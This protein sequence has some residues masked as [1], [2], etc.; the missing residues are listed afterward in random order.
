M[1][2]RARGVF[3]AASVSC[4]NHN[5]MRIT[6][7]GEGHKAS[8]SGCLPLAAPI[9]LSPLL[10]LTPCGPERVWGGGGGA[11]EHGHG[12][13]SLTPEGRTRGV[14][15]AATHRS[16]QALIHER[17]VTPP[18]HPTKKCIPRGR[19]A[20][21][22]KGP[23][24][25]PRERSD[26]WLEEVAEAVGGGYCR[27]QMPLKLAPAVRE[28]VAGHRLGA[29]DG[30]GTPP[31]PSCNTSLQISAGCSARRGYQ[32]WKGDK[33]FGGARKCTRRS[34]TNLHRTQ[35]NCILHPT[36]MHGRRGSMR[37][38]ALGTRNTLE[39]RWAGPQG[40]GPN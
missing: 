9:G 12:G 25:Q 24:R 30:G 28:T 34:P 16:T 4:G 20:L 33:V 14:W 19:D 32:F 39:T 22:G 5:I 13:G 3:L 29:L 38:V 11:R 37:S 26:R 31:S 23:W 10:I 35:Y 17:P 7:W 18:T 40:L 15:H 8:V 2:L 21:E 27:L 6:G 36:Q 1:S